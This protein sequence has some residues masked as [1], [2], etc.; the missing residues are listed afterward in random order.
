M[1]LRKKEI[2]VINL[3]I[4]LISKKSVELLT[5]FY[6]NFSYIQSIWWMEKCQAKC[7]NKE[8]DYVER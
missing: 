1:N 3:K 7:I 2:I 8:W 6:L 5:D 4:R